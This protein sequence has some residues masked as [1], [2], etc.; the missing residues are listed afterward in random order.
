[1]RYEVSQNGYDT[2]PSQV[3]VFFICLLYI[4]SLDYFVFVEFSR[5]A[6]AFILR[7]NAD[8]GCLRMSPR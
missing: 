6:R 3:K 1:M 5:F 4:H 2:A 8:V 7:V